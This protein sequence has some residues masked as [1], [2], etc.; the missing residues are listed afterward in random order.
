MCSVVL[1]VKDALQATEASGG[2]TIVKEGQVSAAR[3]QFL[4]F[5]NER[6]R[7]HIFRRRELRTTARLF[8]GE[9]PRQFFSRL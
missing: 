8:L 9:A 7:P 2:A 5:C 1:P 3:K 4:L 6:Q